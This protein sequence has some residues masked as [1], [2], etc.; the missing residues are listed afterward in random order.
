MVD[1]GPDILDVDIPSEPQHELTMALS[2]GATKSSSPVIF[3]QPIK[4]RYIYA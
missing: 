2:S 4:R 3:L 1:F